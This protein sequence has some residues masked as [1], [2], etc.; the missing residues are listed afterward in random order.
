MS[1][2]GVDGGITAGP[3]VP[4]QYPFCDAHD[5]VTFVT[6]SNLKRFAGAAPTATVSGATAS[7]RGVTPPALARLGL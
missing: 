3:R 5:W 4:L 6:R 7:L 1:T 2:S